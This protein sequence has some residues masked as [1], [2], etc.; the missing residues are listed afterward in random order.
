MLR[1]TCRIAPFM[2][3]IVGKESDKMIKD[4]ELK[5]KIKTLTL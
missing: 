4:V 1:S 3:A 2:Q 5:V